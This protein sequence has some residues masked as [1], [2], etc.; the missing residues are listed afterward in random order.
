MKPGT[1]IDG[2][3]PAGPASWGALC[4]ATLGAFLVLAALA[5]TAGPL[6]GD[7][8]VRGAI[9]AA[10]SPAA[11][12][13]ARW[14][15]YGG[16]WYALVPATVLLLALSGGF[17]E[18]WWL[19]CGVLLGTGANET[20]F[21]HLVGRARPG[22]SSMGF[23]SGHA[24]AAAGFAA[25]LI[26]LAQRARV[27]PGLRITIAGLALLAALLVGLAR[28]VLRAHWPSDVVAGWAL[29]VACL[30][31]GAWWDARSPLPLRGAGRQGAGLEG[32]V[33][34]TERGRRKVDA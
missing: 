34:A 9:L 16:S 27:T 10:V 1:R 17:R 13:L 29:G 28:I 6:P 32:I 22:E 26:Y 15:N 33:M 8:P 24:A 7:A 21:K 20:A 30:S 25:L 12:L 14:I 31:A 5:A 4:L 3:G 18:R 23:P 2:M 11:D 19:W